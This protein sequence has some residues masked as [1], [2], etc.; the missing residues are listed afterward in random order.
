[1]NYTMTMM[2]IRRIFFLQI[3]LASSHEVY[4]SYN[5]I[6]L[7]CNKQRDISIVSI[8]HMYRYRVHN[9]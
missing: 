4:T 7:N 6:Y 1:M 2:K 8:I 5:K 3:R 9:E